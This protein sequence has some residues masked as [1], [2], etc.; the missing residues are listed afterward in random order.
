MSSRNALNPIWEET[1]EI[2]LHLP[3][4]AFIRFNVIDVTSNLTT[5][6][7]VIPVN[8]LRPGYRHLRLHN[9]QDLPLPLTQ[10]FLCS[11]FNEEEVVEDD[12]TLPSDEMPTA[13]QLNRKRMSFLVVH[14]LSEQSPYAILKV[15]E[16]ATTKDV[17]RQAVMKA[18]NYLTS[19]FYVSFVI[20]HF[21]FIGLDSTHEHEYVLLE[22]VVSGSSS[23]QHTVLTGAPTQRMVGMSEMPL[24]VRNKWRSDTK[25]VLKKVGQDP[26]WRARLGNL[27]F[28]PD[29]SKEQE[30]DKDAPEV[31]KT[32]E[33]IDDDFPVSSSTTGSEN[34]SADNF[35]VCVFNVSS[36]VS[37]SI[38]QVKKPCFS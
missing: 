17:I 27:K 26:S 30:K 14:D 1:F 34:S 29:E 11:Q 25:F 23:P 6:Q 13:G 3:E 33:S 10:L 5:A 18:G 12:D 37:Y 7:R 20:Y 19:G 22:E 31:T 32:Q 16:T 24:Q 38:L 2:D 15:P 28:N 4:L 21:R 36:K 35:L 8:R 9:E